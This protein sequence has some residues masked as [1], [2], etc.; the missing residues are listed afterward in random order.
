[1][2]S[3]FGV[4]KE[5]RFRGVSFFAN[6]IELVGNETQTGVDWAGGPGENAHSSVCGDRR[7]VLVN[8]TTL[9]AHTTENEPQT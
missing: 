9:Y 4:G 6:N 5:G 1:M 2:H 3:G 8:R 7:G